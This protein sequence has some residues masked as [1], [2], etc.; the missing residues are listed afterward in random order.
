MTPG[1]PSVEVA[2]AAQDRLGEGPVWDPADRLLRWLDIAAGRVHQLAPS[3]GRHTMFDIGQPVGSFALRHDGG[4]VLAADRGFVRCAADGGDLT[5]IAGF[6]VATPAVR[7]NDGRADPWGGFCAGTMHLGETEARGALFRLAP[8]ETVRELVGGIVCS[9]GLD[10][11]DDRRTLYYIDTPT[12]AVDRFAVDPERG[13]LLGRERFLPVAGPGEPDGMTLDAEGCLWVA[14]WGGGEVRRYTPAGRLD[15]VVRLPV[16]QVTSCAFGGDRLDT[17][18]ITTAH[19]GLNPAARRHEPHAG[20]LFCCT[21]G[22]IGRPPHR[23]GTAAAPAR[24]RAGGPRP[25]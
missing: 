11:S 6:R 13:D 4:L 19:D 18:Y 7:F 22:A 21:P 3:G 9:N 20:D 23:F 14:C 2:L 16:S 5:P 17:L 25:A 10:W 15:R 24:A 8:D 1:G 12:R